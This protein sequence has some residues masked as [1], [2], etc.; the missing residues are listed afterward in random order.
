MTGWTKPFA[1]Y[2]ASCIFVFLA[3]HVAGAIPY[4]IRMPVPGAGK[5]TL[6][7]CIM[8][9]FFPDRINPQLASLLFAV[10]VVLLWLI[11]L[12]LM[13]NRRIVIKI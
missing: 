3:S 7:Q 5:P 6:Q 12:W 10:C 4:L 8:Q 13:Y 9:C 2:G 11:P 1:A